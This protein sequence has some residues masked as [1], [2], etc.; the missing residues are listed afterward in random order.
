MKFSIAH[1]ELESL[2]RTA[3]FSMPKKAPKLVLSACAGRVFVKTVDCIAG[4]ETLVLAGGEVTVP[5]Q[6]FAKLLATYKGTKLLTIEGGPDGLKIQN[7]TMPVLGWNPKPVPP[8][9]FKIF[10]VT[11]LGVT[12]KTA[13][14]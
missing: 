6:N 3:G 1:A 9:E 8:A 14:Q 7:F 10:R 4:I 5:A 12:G 13:A 11:D 2:V